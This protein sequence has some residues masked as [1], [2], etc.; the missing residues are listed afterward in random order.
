MCI[1]IREN[2]EYKRILNIE[3]KNRNIGIKNI[4]KD[5]LKLMR[6][7]EKGAFLHL[8]KN[9]NKR[10]FR[11]NKETGIFDMLYKSFELFKSNWKNENKSIH[12]LILSIEQNTLLHRNIKYSELNKIDEIF[13]INRDCGNIKDIK[14]NGWMV[15]SK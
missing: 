15:V 11:N 2:S 12:L 3:F 7:K 9:S 10:T 14:G 1:F 5:I 4:A 8:L 6:E 13:F